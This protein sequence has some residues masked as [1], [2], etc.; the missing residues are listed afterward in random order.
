MEIFALSDIHNSI[1]NL[2]ALEKKAKKTQIAIICGDLTTLGP[3]ENIPKIAKILQ[4]RKILA[5]PGNMDSNEVLEKMK[6]MNI[7][8]HCN[9]KRLNGIEF[10]GFGGGLKGRAGL[11]TFPEKEIIQC[12][13]KIVSSKSVLITHLPPFN[14][15][16]DL[17]QNTTHIGS[18][19]V[20]KIIEEKKPALH[21]C[22]HVH[23]ALN[24]EKIG[25][26][27][28]V[29]VGSVKE[30]TAAIIKLSNKTNQ[31]RIKRIELK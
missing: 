7:S 27:L 22:G 19:A 26:T 24:E 28:S 17:A 30:G 18:S 23:E 1:E 20:R 25:E 2:K 15:K 5:V 31:I 12:L 9:C 4:P 3:K 21:L 10:C 6:D 13:N 8:I 29:N 11:L 16:L 14:S